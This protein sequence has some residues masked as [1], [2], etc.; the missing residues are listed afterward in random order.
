MVSDGRFQFLGELGAVRNSRDWNQAGKSKLWLYN[1]HYLDDLNAAGADERYDQLQSLIYQWNRENPPIAGNGWEPYPLSLRTVNLVKWYG[2]Q[3]DPCDHA[4]TNLRRQVKALEAQL[5]WHILANHLFANAKALIFAGTFYSDSLGDKW[6]NLGVRILDK[7]LCKQFFRDGGHFELSP[8]YHSILLWDLCDLVNLAD[9]TGVPELLQRAPEWRKTIERG[10]RWLRAMSHPDGEI[11]FFNDSAFGIAPKPCEIEDYAA[12]LGV[13]VPSRSSSDEFVW[14]HLKDSGYIAI[15]QPKAKL[16]LD[17][18]EVGPTYQPGHAHADTLSFELSLF[19]VR[20]FVNSGISTYDI[21][22]D[23]NYQR[24]TAAHNTLEINGENS[25]QVWAG[26]RVARRA[27][28]FGLFAGEKNGTFHAR[29]SHN[30]Y[31]WLPKAPNHKRSWQLSS[32]RLEV[33]DTVN[34]AFETAIAYFHLHPDI[35]IDSQNRLWLA[36]GQVVNW[37]VQGG[38]ARVVDSSWSPRFGSKVD[39]RC[40]EVHLEESEIKTSF[41]WH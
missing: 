24:G 25:S 31:R 33:V 9:R 34:G 21:G 35:D 40:I 15:E 11:A 5:E 19:G 17:V 10:L 4:L 1:L 28:P 23:R 14:W 29:C 26:F 22:T 20:V 37:H 18:G 2:R 27:S 41:W 13:N 6:L 8:M 30:G 32:N 7:E 38:V 39:S 3:I 36:T 12:M 16:I